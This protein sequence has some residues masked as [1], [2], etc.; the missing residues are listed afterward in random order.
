[1]IKNY[2]SGSACEVFIE[3]ENKK[4]IKRVHYTN[5]GIENGHNKLVHEINY[6][7]Q[8]NKECNLF[9][10]ILSSYYKD[11]Y[12]Y[13]EIEY[14]F[15]GECF[16]DLIFDKNIKKEY[17][18][19][20]LEKIMITLM[21]EYYIKLDSKINL[22]YWD[23]CYINRTIRRL[24]ISIDMIKEK[25]INM[26]KLKKCILNGITVNGI[27]YAS[28]YKYMDYLKSHKEYYNYIQ[29]NNT[30][31]SHHD[32]ISENILIKRGK[33]SISDFKMIDP[34]GE[35]ET[36]KENRHFIYDMG[37][38]LFGLDCYGLF[39]KAY[40][41]NNFENFKF[42]NISDRNYKLT[43]NVDS[44]IVNNLMYLQEIFLDYFYKYYTKLV[45]ENENIELQ[46]MF[47]A[48][49]MYIPDIPCRMIDEKIEELCIIFYARGSMFLH[50]LML[51]IYGRDELS[52]DIDGKLY[53]H[54][55]I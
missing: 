54:W 31:R 50:E 1:M 38:M 22:N 8:M 2:Q 55:P 32:L 28:A 51:K 43:Y 20:S 39:R 52:S 48:A 7:K 9:P 15:N 36:G 44:F 3:K 10:N 4:V 46:L 13:A 34:R 45:S 25:N 30:Y 19:K 12:L 26:N 41:E 29:P 49:C 14:L 33:N 37:K 47:S 27:Y 6:I 21:K 16:T 5:E 17:L 42:E 18:D 53:K 23:D 35:S 11:D 24:N 40:H